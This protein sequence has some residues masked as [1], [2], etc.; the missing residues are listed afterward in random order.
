MLQGQ[1]PGK[2]ILA[3]LLAIVAAG[4][5]AVAAFAR[6]CSRRADWWGGSRDDV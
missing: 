1:K 3:I 2:R 4:G 5:L 6:V